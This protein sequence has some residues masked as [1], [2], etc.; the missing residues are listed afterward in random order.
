MKTE[1]SNFRKAGI[2]FIKTFIFLFLGVK[3]AFAN[4]YA[5]LT[6][7]NLV[8]IFIVSM[9]MA[10]I[11]WLATYMHMKVKLTTTEWQRDSIKHKAD[12]MYEYSNNTAEYSR[13]EVKHQ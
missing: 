5:R 9:T 1:K 3:D 13:I 2:S 8:V 4:L 12:S 10:T 7:C 6:K 11:G